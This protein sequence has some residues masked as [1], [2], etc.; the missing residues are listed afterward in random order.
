MTPSDRRYAETHE[1]VK[2]E[3][4]VAIIGISDYAQEALG[5]IT[6]IEL[7]ETDH[8]VA[9]DE[10]CG[11]VESVKAASD[12]NSPL[13]GDIIEV[14]D[15]LDGNPELVNEDAYGEGWVFKMVN[16]SMAQYEDLMDAADY[17][18]TQDADEE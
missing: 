12:L 17:E 6:F 10:E 8:T 13:D 7:P 16:F 3:D 1:W 2:I 5:D 4:D 11:V 9:Q 14:N 18:A 15:A